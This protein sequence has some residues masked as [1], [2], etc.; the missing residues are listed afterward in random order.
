MKVLVSS[1]SKY[2]A[3][4]DIAKAVADVLAGRGL[5]VSVVPP[6]QAGGI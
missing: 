3:T 4:S 6:S 2:G 5:E 1:A